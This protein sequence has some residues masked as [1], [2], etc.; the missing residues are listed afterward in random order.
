MFYLK[1]CPRCH[2][3]LYQGEDTFGEYISCLP[4]GHMLTEGEEVLLRQ[5]FPHGGVPQTAVTQ[6]RDGI[7]F[8]D[9][10]VIFFEKVSLVLGDEAEA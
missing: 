7:R 9:E 5:Q 4:C 1:S 2:G 10:T 8:L 6:N 3:D